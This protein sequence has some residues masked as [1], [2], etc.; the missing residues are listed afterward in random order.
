MSISIVTAVLA[1]GSGVYAE[2]TIWTSKDLPGDLGTALREHFAV[3]ENKR[4]VIDAMAFKRRDYS[5]E[6]QMVFQFKDESSVYFVR[7]LGRAAFKIYLEKSLKKDDLKGLQQQI[8][9]WIKPLERF[10]KDRKSSISELKIEILSTGADSILIGERVSSK[11]RF[12]QSLRE[13]YRAKLVTPIAVLGASLLLSPEPQRIDFAIFNTLTAVVVV[14]A[15]VVEATF[16]KPS[17]I[18]K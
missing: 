16:S 9:D 1:T 5:E 14:L 18:Y 6:N 7:K 2:L 3:T 4:A 8:K 17:I 11:G 13:E 10:L 12:W 15:L